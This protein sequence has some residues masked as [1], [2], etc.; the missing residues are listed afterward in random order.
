M[1]HKKSIGFGFRGSMLILY[2]AL[3]FFIY[4]VF[5]SFGQNIQASANAEMFGW[6]QASVSTIYTVAVLI[7]VFFQLAFSRKI[8]NGK[9][10]K[11][12]SVIFMGVGV[13]FGFLMATI[14]VNEAL[15][16]FFFA[17]AIFFSITGSTF[18]IGVL[19]GQWFPRRKGTVMGIATLAFPITTGVGT[20]IFAAN[21][22]AKGPLMA[23]L[24]FFIIAIIGILIAVF[25][26]KDYPEQCGAYRDNDKN[27]T[28]EIAKAMMEAEIEAKKKSV[29]TLGKCFACR[30][31]WFMTIPAGI[32]LATSVGAMTQMVGILGFYPD[33][34]EKYGSI[35]MVCVTVI[36]C[37]GSYIIG[38]L[39]TKFGTKKA[40]ILTCIISVISGVVGFIA[41]ASTLAAGLL[42]LCIFMGSASNFAV[43]LTAQYWRREDFPAVYGIAN[44]VINIIQAF[45]PMMVVMISLSKGFH[46]TF[47]VIGILGAVALVLILLFNPEHVKETDRKYRKK[48]GLPVEK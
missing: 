10:V 40:V 42:I 48:A 15:W 44:P 16:L 6:N 13:V 21:Y 38:L 19:I 23:Y 18:V 9:S 7:S 31:F 35:L 30:D 25:F 28:P 37:L 41:T 39:D 43:S 12:I 17:A 45:G 33:F 27:M 14:F 36:A 46:V 5:N 47:G 24:P 4:T 26:I 20:S 34:Y 29:W 22:F 8:V 3:A 2:Q 32:L 1:E 11:W